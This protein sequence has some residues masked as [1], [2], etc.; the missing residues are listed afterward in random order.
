MVSSSLGGRSTGADL[1]VRIHSDYFVGVM[2]EI[3]KGLISTSSIRHPGRL[4][5]RGSTDGLTGCIDHEPL[6][7]GGGGLFTLSIDIP[8]FRRSGWNLRRASQP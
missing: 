7:L 3:T 6:P 8:K 2:L 4:E 5:M 1:Q